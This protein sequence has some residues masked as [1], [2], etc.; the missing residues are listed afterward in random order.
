MKAAN[1][2]TLIHLTIILAF[3][4]ILS[5]TMNDTKVYESLSHSFEV[6]ADGLPRPEAEW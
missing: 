6:H 4:T 1:T 5:H 3:P 2:T